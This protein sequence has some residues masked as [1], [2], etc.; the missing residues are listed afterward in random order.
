MVGNDTGPMFILTDRSLEFT[1]AKL[2][3]YNITFAFLNSHC[4]CHNLFIHTS[5]PPLLLF[6]WVE[7]V[8]ERL[9]YY[10]G[11]QLT[12]V[13]MGHITNCI[14]CMPFSGCPRL[15]SVALPTSQ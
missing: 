4:C 13:G 2:H 9:R 6:S 8:T 10:G 3:A 15:E 11:T 12:V 1:G 14:L 7:S 5:P